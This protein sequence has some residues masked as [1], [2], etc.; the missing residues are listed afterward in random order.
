MQE[1]KR[2]RKE[3]TLA[4]VNKFDVSM[5]SHAMSLEEKT[6][7]CFGPAWFKLYSLG[8]IDEDTRLTTYG[9]ALV[10]ESRRHS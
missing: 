10:H 8:L 1:I 9:K 7:Y 3:Y 4:D 5:L 2:K 6:F